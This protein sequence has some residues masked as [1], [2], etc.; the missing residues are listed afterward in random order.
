[1]IINGGCPHDDM[2]LTVCVCACVRV[3]EWPECIMC[4]SQFMFNMT[5][6]N[7]SIVYL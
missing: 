7:T 1:M 3:C 4:A 2:E 6:S 5:F